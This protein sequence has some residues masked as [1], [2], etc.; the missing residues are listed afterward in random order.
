LTRRRGTVRTFD[1]RRGLGEVE[2]DDGT[3][4]PFHC[5]A[6]ADG[7]RRIE[8]GALVEFDVIAGLLGR[9]EAAEI[10]RQVR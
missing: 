2:A 6:I 9:W 1:E 4:F 7:S 5:T 10:K 8:P 3:A